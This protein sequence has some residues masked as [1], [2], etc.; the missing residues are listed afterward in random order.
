MPYLKQTHVQGSYAITSKRKYYIYKASGG[1]SRHM[2][3]A[4]GLLKAGSSYV[5]YDARWSSVMT[6][7]I[8]PRKG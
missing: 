6:A 3:L 8:P 1:F 7:L 4:G 5:R 2:H